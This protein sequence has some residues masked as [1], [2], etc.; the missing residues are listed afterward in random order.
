L[1]GTAAHAIYRQNGGN[2]AACECL[3]AAMPQRV[4]AGGT[5]ACWRQCRCS[6]CTLHGGSAAAYVLAAMP[7][8]GSAAAA[9]GSAA[10]GGNAAAAM[11][12]K[13]QKSLKR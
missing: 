5:A 2:A 4:H 12:Q 3:L 11:P 10:A 9:G 8:G 1:S 13:K 7:H 6:E